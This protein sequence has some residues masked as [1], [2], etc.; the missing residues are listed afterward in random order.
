V[1]SVIFQLLDVASTTKA[2]KDD[3]KF[4]L[5]TTNDTCVFFGHPSLSE[6]DMELVCVEVFKEM[7]L[8]NGLAAYGAPEFTAAMAEHPVLQPYV[9][10]SYED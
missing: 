3:M 10:R 8:E 4:V 6:E 7:E 1:R 5:K 2:S 9:V